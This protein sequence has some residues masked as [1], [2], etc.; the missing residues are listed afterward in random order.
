MANQGYLRA[1]GFGNAGQRPFEVWVRWPWQRRW[2]SDVAF[3]PRLKARVTPRERPFLGGVLSLEVLP[4]DPKIGLNH[5][6]DPGWKTVYSTW[7]HQEWPA[8]KRR[9]LKLSAPPTL[10]EGE[11][12]YQCRIE[13]NEREEVNEGEFATLTHSYFYVPVPF[14]LHGTSTAVPLVAAGIAALSAVLSLLGALLSAIT[15]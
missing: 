13:L 15:G 2:F 8:E 6:D 14:R 11:G 5:S 12:T 1:Y 9:K 10:L 4:F 3:T 7:E